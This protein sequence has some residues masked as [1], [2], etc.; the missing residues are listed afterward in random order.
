LIRFFVSLLLCSGLLY[1]GT[2]IF[3]QQAVLNEF[4]TFFWSTLIFLILSTAVIYFFLTRSEPSAFVQRYLMSTVLK[5]FGYCVYNVVIILMD[6]E[7]AGVNVAFFL[8]TYFLFTVLEL[9]FLYRK[10]SQ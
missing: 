3:N 1:G 2:V 5:L 9:A 8:I 7:N 6:R 4:P 10:M